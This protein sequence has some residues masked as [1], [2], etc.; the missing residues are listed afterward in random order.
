MIRHQLTVF[1]DP[2]TDPELVRSLCYRLYSLT[3]TMRDAGPVVNLFK[4]FVLSRAQETE[5]LFGEGQR[6]H[7]EAPFA[8]QLVDNVRVLLG[9][10]RYIRY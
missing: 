7:F 4:L 2:N 5:Q 9:P 6:T 3:C 10:P 8:D 1:A